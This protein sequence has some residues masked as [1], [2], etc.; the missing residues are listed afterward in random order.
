MLPEHRI[1]E[2]LNASARDRD[3]QI[4]Q[5][6]DDVAQS[7]DSAQSVREHIDEAARHWDYG[8]VRSRDP[9]K[10]LLQSMTKIWPDHAQEVVAT[11]LNNAKDKG[12]G[13]SFYRHDVAENIRRILEKQQDAGQDL[14]LDILISQTKIGERGNL[15]AAL[16]VI[17]SKH[18][19]VSSEIRDC[20]S[21]V[22]I[23]HFGV[24]KRDAEVFQFPSEKSE[25]T[26]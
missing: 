4:M 18:E 24:E 9:A 2:I 5:M 13:E 25:P 1:S 15:K 3:T 19:S 17:R 26:L 20:I 14:S 8:G 16:N 23:E 10:S 22:F 11:M 12:V 7:P 6:V 21:E